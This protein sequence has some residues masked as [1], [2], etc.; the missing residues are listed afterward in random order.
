MA[1]QNITFMVDF[2]TFLQNQFCSCC[3]CVFLVLH[4]FLFPVMQLNVKFTTKL[5][6][7][8]LH[9]L[10]QQLCL[11]FSSLIS[12]SGLSE[13]WNN[14]FI[15]NSNEHCSTFYYTKPQHVNSLK[16]K[17]KMVP[18]EL[19]TFP[20]QRAFDSNPIQ[21]PL[22][23]YIY[24]WHSKA[25]LAFIYFLNQPTNTQ[26]VQHI[27]QFKHTKVL[28]VWAT[29]LINKQHCSCANI[30][31]NKLRFNCFKPD[32]WLAGFETTGI[33]CSVLPC[34]WLVFIVWVAWFQQTHCNVFHF[35]NA[36]RQ[37]NSQFNSDYF[38]QKLRIWL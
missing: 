25:A 32:I 17:H 12:F 29:Q 35:N 15:K 20:A 21:H 38:M 8:L 24:K 26:K 16:Q 18:Q 10:S 13:Y 4:S 37:T 9:S 23:I 19:S 1:T 11:Y 7:K 33:Y 3:L 14:I 27:I 30:K 5:S 28:Q 22:P 34:I 31:T 6:E 2:D 36:L